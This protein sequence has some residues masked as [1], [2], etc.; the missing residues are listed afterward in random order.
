MSV[1][2]VILTKDEEQD[3]PECLESLAW[4]EDL[5][6]LDSGST[7][8]TCEVAKA[9]GAKVAVNEFKS[10]GQQRNWALDN[11]NLKFDWILFLDADECSTTKFRNDVLESIEHA[12]EAT[13]GFF[14]CWKL[15]REGIWL[16]R[17]D[18]FPRW[19][20]RIAR[21]NR[22]R[23]KSV[24]HG[25]MESEVD[26]NLEYIREPYLHYPFS[27]GME[28]WFQKHKRYAKQEAHERLR[29]P[30]VFRNL[31]CR[32]ASRRNI[33]LKKLCVRMPC[34]P[35]LR[36]LHAYIW[37]MG[38]LEGATGYRYCRDIA[39]YEAMIVNNFKELRRRGQLERA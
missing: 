19:Q 6:V 22:V 24:G 16:R 17:S 20:M 14:C 7:D 35:W 37:R 27:K 15:M 34:W 1:S 12:E 28:H 25:Q 30:F 39:H 5:Q 4:C 31:F 13:A 10:F 36:F 18:A 9:H 23:F 21:R 11:L 3:L 32:H 38:F 8:S 26:G 2:T 29:E 33:A